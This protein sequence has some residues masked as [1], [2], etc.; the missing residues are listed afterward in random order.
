[1][2]LELSPMRRLPKLFLLAVALAAFCASPATAKLTPTI[3]EFPAS[4]PISAESG[5]NA[6]AAGP[7]GALWFIDPY[8]NR[9]GRITTE[10]T[11]TLQAPIPGASFEYDITAG[12]DGAM[13]FV[14]Q[15]PSQVGRV[16]T[17]G[18]ILTKDFADPIA[19]PTKIVSG[20]ENALWIGEAAAG[21]IG[22]V[23]AST[24]L[25]TPDESRT[26]SGGPTDL[27]VGPDGNLWFTE[28]NESEV[29]RMSPAGDVTYFPLPSGIKNPEM[30]TAGPDGALWYWTLN[31]GTI[32]RM[33]ADALQQPFALPEAPFGEITTGPDGALW[34]ADFDQIMRVTVDGVAE[35]FPLQDKNAGALGITAGPDGNVWFTEGNAGLIG[36]I[37]TPPN[38]KTGALEKAGA[39]S[40]TVSGAV[41]GHSQPTTV[42][43]EY[44]TAAGGPTQASQPLQ[45]APSAAEQPVSIAVAGLAPKTSYRYRLVASNP[46]GATPGAFAE[47]STTAL[48]RCKVKRAKQGKNGSIKLTLKCSS[49]TS[50]RAKATAGK[51][52]YG[53]G[54]AKVRKGKA[55]LRIEPT[56][57]ARVRLEQTGR[58]KVRVAIKAIGGGTSTPLRKSI[59]VKQRPTL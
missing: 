27:A 54:R 3:T 38:T 9:V 33:S 51:K 45:L 53:K 24:P 19:N 42:T 28:Y 2:K 48:P 32:V 25:Q 40:I 50:V 8:A 1:M 26:T 29:G 43:V 39:K 46:T 5:P 7:D 36:R 57:K 20:P 37:T 16:D 6:I 44:G 41:S 30:I 34:I 23:P 55:T 21:A 47:G 11:L 17:A 58:L 31:P 4:N 56:K 15:G 22:R 10:G 59:R 49:S 14:S 52:L 18:N 35:E 12:P 13:W